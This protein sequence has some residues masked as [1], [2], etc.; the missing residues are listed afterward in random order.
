[1]PGANC[2]RR[3]SHGT[4]LVFVD[5]VFDRPVLL[6][7]SP[8]DRYLAFV[9][10]DLQNVSKSHFLAYDFSRDSNE[11]YSIPYPKFGGVL[12]TLSVYI[13]NVKSGKTLRIPRPNEYKNS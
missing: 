2:A 7:W 4:L 6:S 8:S 11:Q 3:T 9:K 5:E 10:I 13:Y 1:M 12:P